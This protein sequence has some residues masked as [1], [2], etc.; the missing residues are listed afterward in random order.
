MTPKEIAAKAAYEVKNLANF[1]QSGTLGKEMGSLFMFSRAQATGAVRAIDSL[2]YIL[3]VEVAMKDLSAAERA[4]PQIVAE[5]KKNYDVKATRARVLAAV[6]IGLGFASYS[7]MFMGA[8]DDELNDNKVA[9]DDA[10]LWTRAMRFT[11]PGSDNNKVFQLPWGFG[12]GALTAWGAQLGILVNGNQTY[13][14]F[15]SNSVQIGLDSFVPLPVSRISFQEHAGKAIAD[16]LT[17][18]VARPFIEYL[19]NMN[20]L[21][22]K[23]YDDSNLSNT[24]DAFKGRGSTPE[25]LNDFA[26]HLF[27]LSDGEVDLNP[28]TISFLLSSYV[29][30]VTQ[31]ANT[32]DSI[33]MLSTDEKEFENLS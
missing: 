1:E 13:G 28:N 6:L 2:S 24:P 22:R 29:N 31:F 4:D 18:T 30:G 33:S 11:L 17:P 21:G 3:P 10:A 25:W 15:L 32:V 23:I 26:V 5:F 16:T 12:L 8:D 7:M 20:G 9:K 27:D 19:M 14:E